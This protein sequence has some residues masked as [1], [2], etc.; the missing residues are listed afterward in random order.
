MRIYLAGPDVFRADVRERAARLKALCAEQGLVGAFP[1]DEEA[2]AEGEP[3]SR[4]IFRQNVKLID[5][6]DAVLANLTPFRGVGADAGTA[7]E[8]G[9]AF[10]AGKRVHGYTA[11]ADDLAAR[12]RAALPA[13]R[14]PERGWVDAGGDMIEDF[15]LAE[16]LM[17]IESIIVAGGVF[18]A[19]AFAGEDDLAIAARALDRIAALKP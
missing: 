13:T 3:L 18:E 17:L 11:A 5:A 4:A 12:T 15:G 7:W 1:L 9:Y 19:P 16:N 2:K 6:C 14:D 10:A 8:L